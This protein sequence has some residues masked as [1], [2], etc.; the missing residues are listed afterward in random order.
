MEAAGAPAQQSQPPAAAL[1]HVAQLLADKLAA[2]QIVL[3]VEKPVIA[4]AFAIG[5]QPNSHPF[6]D[7]PFRHRGHRCC[8]FH[9]RS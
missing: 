8:L 6:E 7:F 9:A 1:R 2:L 5:D 3:L 4:L